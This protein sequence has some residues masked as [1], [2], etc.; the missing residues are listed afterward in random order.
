MENKFLIDLSVK[1]GL[2]AAEMSKLA[3]MVHQ[4]GFPDIDSR[5]FRRVAEYICEMK[6]LELPPE[7]L[8]EELKLKGLI[9]K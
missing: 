7:E 4:V 8:V 5:G 3:S 6:M 9:G 2:N 1:Y